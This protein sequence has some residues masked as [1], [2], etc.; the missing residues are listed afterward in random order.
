MT[1]LILL[2]HPNPGSLNHAIAATCRDTALAFGHEVVLHDLCAEGFDAHLPAEEIRRSAELPPTIA[3]HCADLA[4][5]DG[6]II[7]HPNWWGMPPAVLTGWV[8]RVVR[9]G[10]AYEFVDGDSGE[11]VPR[12]LLRARWALVLNTS[13]TA[14]KRETAVFGDPLERIWRDCVFGLCGVTD[15]RRHVFRTVVT[16]SAEERAGWL[17]QAAELV[18]AAVSQ[19]G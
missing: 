14:A 7:V 4:A 15:V 8:D 17:A 6:I 3:Q 1:I 2:A 9:P 5:A 19:A 18:R 10:V 11:G 13:D 16:S 12:G